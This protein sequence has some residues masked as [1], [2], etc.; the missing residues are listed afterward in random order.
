MSLLGLA[1][2][3]QNVYSTTVPPIGARVVTGMGLSFFFFFSEYT[4]RGEVNREGREEEEEERAGSAKKQKQNRG[5]P[6]SW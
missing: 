3:P 6:S 4:S 5:K 2:Q 1:K